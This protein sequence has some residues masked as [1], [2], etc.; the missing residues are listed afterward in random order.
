MIC[1]SEHEMKSGYNAQNGRDFLNTKLL[2]DEK[3]FFPGPG[4]MQNAVPCTPCVI[5]EKNRYCTVED[6]ARNKRRKEKAEKI[7]LPLICACVVCTWRIGVVWRIG[8]S[9]TVVCSTSG[10]VP[11]ESMSGRSLVEG[12]RL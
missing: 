2:T 8:Y 3:H 11:Y 4:P 7:E 6:F 10:V 1:L 12:G 9:T 5:R